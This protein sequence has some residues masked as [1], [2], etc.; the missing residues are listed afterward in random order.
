LY[1]FERQHLL[2]PVYGSFTEG[3]D[4]AEAVS[5]AAALTAS[6]CKEGWPRVATPFREQ[7]YTVT[8]KPIPD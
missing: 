3:F 5:V 7:S 1:R 6:S 4:T 2:A 8:L